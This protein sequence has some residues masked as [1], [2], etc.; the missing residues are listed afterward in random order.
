VGEKTYLITLVLALVATGAFSG[1]LAGLLGVGGGIVIVPVLFQVFDLFGV[2][3]SIRMQV[4]VAT[5]LATIIPTS[6]VSARSH[7]KKQSVD[8]ALLRRL[9]PTTF[10]GVIAGTLLA[11]SVSGHILTAVFATVALIVAVKMALGPEALV[12]GKTLPGTAGVGF[13]GAVIGTVS[14]M[15]GIG[16]GTLTVPLLSLFSYP[17]HRAVG[18]AA[19]L[20]LIISVP[21]A[22]G[23]AVAGYGHSQLPPFSLGYVNWAGFLAIVPTSILAA[24]YGARLAHAISRVW[25]SRAFAF[26]LTITSIKLFIGLL[27]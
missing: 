2:D 5:S 16:G 15:M 26:F 1:F 4:A 27:H 17:I 24:P 14:A 10:I 22:I 12:I 9:A 20:G 19:A 11:S 13:M 23:F 6:I 3:Q 8:Q 18:T 25:L 7:W 21:G